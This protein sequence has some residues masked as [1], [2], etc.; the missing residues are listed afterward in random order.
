M[1]AK[2]SPNCTI[3]EAQCK[4]DNMRGGVSSRELSCC[5]RV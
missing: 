5:D 3:F 2:Y 1:K 4:D